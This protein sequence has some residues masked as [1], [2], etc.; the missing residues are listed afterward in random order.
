MSMSVV[1]ILETRRFQKGLVLTCN[2][3]MKSSASSVMILS[4]ICRTDLPMS[5]RL[6]GPPN[7]A[8]QRTGAAR[9]SFMSRWFYGIIGFGGRAL[10]APVAELGRWAA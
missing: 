3:E 8:L 5:K 10:S 9:F 6:F 7:K 4:N 2:M 1:V